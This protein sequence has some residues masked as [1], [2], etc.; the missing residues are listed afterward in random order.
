[1][2]KNKKITF[3]KNIKTKTKIIMKK[4]LFA[5]GLVAIMLSTVFVGC[6]KG[7][8]DPALSLL[9]RKARISGIWNISTGTWTTTNYNAKKGGSVFMPSISE[10]VLNKMFDDKGSSHTYQYSFANGQLTIVS[11]GDT[12]VAEYT[13]E[14][15]F[16]KDGTFAKK[17]YTKY[18]DDDETLE[19]WSEYEGK[20]FFMDGDKD[21][22]V[23]NKE[24]VAVQLTKKYSKSLYTYVLYGTTHSVET[25]DTD[26]YTGSTASEFVVISLDKLSNKE[27]IVKIDNK[28]TDDDGDYNENTGEITFTQE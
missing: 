22:E 17:T 12:D 16:D 3:A 23:K 11:D 26:T 10:E 19:S 1:M 20:W 5:F 6:K 15:T 7:E 2:R 9:S 21:L 25:V 27:I 8:N 4:K 13:E 18:T 14:V 24:R 28:T